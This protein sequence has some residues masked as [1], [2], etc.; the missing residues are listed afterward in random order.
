MIK[1]IAS[2]LD[3]TLLR[4]DHTLS[5]KTADL[6]KRLHQ[7]GIKVVLASGRPVPGLT[8][9]NNQLALRQ[10]DDFSIYLNGALV[11]DNYE[12]ISIL[13]RTLQ[14]QA[15]IELGQLAFQ[16]KIPVEYISTETVYSTTD[17]GKSNYASFAPATMTFRYIKQ[18][19][20]K[21]DKPIYKV[22]FANTPDVIDAIQASINFSD[23]S[24]TRSRR[25]FLEFMPRGVNKAV[26]LESI[27]AHLDYS[28]D[29]VMAFGDEEND[30]EMLQYA[31]VSVAVANARNVVKTNAQYVTDSNEEDGVFR[32]LEKW[33][34]DFLK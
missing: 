28:A 10:P 17:F 26:G 25:E 9:L 31:G 21:N 32:F 29:Q 22:G 6:L 3:H 15:L 24:V 27:V 30:I 20:F 8:D 7:L 11:L 16:L 13:G 2:D 18:A 1:I 23:I 4:E 14:A 5:P 33:F 34:A 12:G 19:A